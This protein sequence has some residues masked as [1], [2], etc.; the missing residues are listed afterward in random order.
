MIDP[1]AYRLAALK[2]GAKLYLK[3]G[4][5]PN[6][7]WTLSNMVKTVNN[8]LNTNHPC[9]RKGLEACITDIERVLA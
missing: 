2:S 1:N 3:S 7:M 8:C 4:I 5:K 6:R 9:T